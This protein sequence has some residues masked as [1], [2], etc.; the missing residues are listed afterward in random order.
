MTLF[1][2]WR[3]WACGAA[4]ALTG[5]LLAG[6][7]P[8]AAPGAQPWWLNLHS[9]T[10]VQ[11]LTR[12]AQEPH[13][14]ITTYYQAEWGWQP[15]TWFGLQTE[16]EG[17]QVVG[18]RQTEHLGANLGSQ[19]R[20]NEMQEDPDLF[21]PVLFLTGSTPGR[22]L[23]WRLGKIS[24]ESCFDDNRVARAKRTKFIAQPFFRNPAVATASKGL[25]GYLHWTAS[26]RAELALCASDA[27]AHGTLSGLTT[28]RGEWFRSAE[29]T[30]RPLTLPARAAVRLLA[31]ATERGG[32]RDGGWGLNADCE[33]T[34]KWVV[35]ARA[36]SGSEQFARSREFFSGGIAWEA[37]FGRSR[38]FLGL[39][40][41]QAK[42]VRGGMHAENL[43]EVIYRWQFNRV[44]ALSPDVQYIRHPAL[45]NVG[46]AWA[47]GLRWSMAYTR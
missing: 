3:H 4:F 17:G 47:F 2:N 5:P 24:P 22:E 36:G 31:W 10:V 20:L 34:P 14:L 41:A 9:S 23:S 33:L 27:N 11:A 19:W 16:L 45:S 26:P 40:L 43:A 12:A 35:F 28:W 46:S 6:T 30:V 15:S 13:S 25:G 37:P 38:D 29:L 44:F 7:W 42:A 32:V 39:G 1:S 18:Q 21:V 8:A